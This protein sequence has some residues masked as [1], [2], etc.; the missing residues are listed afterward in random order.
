[1]AEIHS[2]SIILRDDFDSYHQLQLN[3]NICQVLLSFIKYALDKW[4]QKM[5]PSK[6][7]LGP[8]PLGAF[9]YFPNLCI[10]YLHN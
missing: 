3:P 10:R 1:M 5:S 4:L 7:I 2:D 9:S 8:S 6:T